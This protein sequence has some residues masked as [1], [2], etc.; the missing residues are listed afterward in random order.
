VPAEFQSCRD[1]L[2]DGL[3]CP[4]LGL[5]VQE[6]IGTDAAGTLDLLDQL[7]EHIRRCALVVHLVG[8]LT[9]DTAGLFSGALL[10]VR[11]PDFGQRF[12]VLQPFLAVDGP[13][14][15]YAQWE[16]WLALY[17]G[18]RLLVAVP[19][20]G[21]ARDSL[22]A[23]NPRQQAL[24]RAHLARLAA[25]GWHPQ[26]CFASPQR[27]VAQVWKAGLLD[28]L[29]ETGR[30][31]RVHALPGRSLGALF[32]GRDA[33]METLARRF[34]AVPRR[35][36]APATVLAL[37]GP[38]GV[39]KTRLALEY[40]W[41]R[42]DEHPVLLLADAGSP[43]A[44]RRHLAALCGPAALNLAE[45][46]EPAQERR[47]AAVLA[48]LR[49]Q[50]GWLLILDG[51][52][53]AEAAEAVEALLP[54]LAGGH[55][56]VTGNASSWSD[57]VQAQPVDGLSP[58]AAAEFLLQRTQAGRPAQPDDEASAS[59]LAA[60]L[61]QLPL[62]L[63]LAGAC[64]AQRRSSLAQYLVQWAWHRE[65]A[66][67][68]LDARR[69]QCPAPVAIAWHASFGLLSP[70]ARRLLQRLAWLAPAPV[71]QALLDVAPPGR[72][73]DE[74]DPGDALAELAAYSLAVRGDDRPV[75]TVHRLVQ[76]L[77][78]RRQGPRRAGVAVTRMWRWLARRFPRTAGHRRWR[79][80]PAASALPQAL[81]WIEDAFFLGDPMDARGWPLLDLLAPHALAAMHWADE[82]GMAGATAGLLGQAGMLFYAQ[83]RHAEAE[84]LMRRAVAVA[85]AGFGRQH[86]RV[87]TALNNLAQL[88]QDTQRLD[89]AETC[90]RRALTIDEARLGREHPGVALR[91]N[92]L[93]L[94]LKATDRAAEAEPLLRRALA[95]DEARLGQQHP[96]VARDLGNLAALMKATNRP[97]EAEPLLRRAVALAETGAGPASVEAAIP[98]GSLALL[99]HHARRLDEAEPLMRRALGQLSASLGAGHPYASTVRRHYTALLREQG[100]GE[101]EIEGVLAELGAGE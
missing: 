69:T 22:H 57:A 42:Q 8:D 55:V 34:G 85:E 27:L 67:A 10:H 28:L 35:T 93:A 2:R 19:E 4:D 61:E 33:L 75:F 25:L 56:L 47:L 62:A 3:A 66:K 50:P 14:L 72:A 71:P 73:D 63:E 51:V 52:D 13:S 45:R 36:D 81:G 7:D 74:G 31:R 53:T 44:L 30:M 40:A 94:L 15:P 17:H 12:P 87:A 89:E 100:R 77:T 29:V 92:N 59:A 68:W 46:H 76:E 64:I 26:A 20:S 101:E 39:G 82:A 11:Y 65:E 6:D 88:L 38:V 95:I 54:R 98:L 78:R 1:A 80:V 41:S 43:Q 37:S 83:A 86:L 23:D 32:R 70:P 58:A 49:R 24:Q 96:A 90:M 9:G 97:D 60:E 16:A 91:L 21:A 48:W 99:L 79:G 18:K 84:P 5:T